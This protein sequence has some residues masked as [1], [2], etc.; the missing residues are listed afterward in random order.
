MA[1]VLLSVGHPPAHLTFSASANAWDDTT[2]VGNINIPVIPA[3]P[4]PEV[5]VVADLAARTALAPTK[6][7]QL[8]I[9]TNDATNGNF[10]I[11]VATGLS[12]GNWTLKVGSMGAQNSNNVLITGGTVSGITDLAVADG[13]TGASTAANAR[14]NLNVVSTDPTGVNLDWS[15]SGS[16]WEVVNANTNFTFSNVI[17]GASIMFAVS[18]LGAFTVGFPA[19]IKWPGGTPPVHSGT[20][21]TDVYAL[22]VIN[23]II[24]GSVVQDYTT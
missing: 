11:W 19:G 20:G 8:L 1:E 6:L 14:V 21:K 17:D 4:A 12:A 2:Q 23:S 24:Y 22:T 5:V 15:L 16:F 3:T 7:N 9:Q 18:S 10:S 13:G